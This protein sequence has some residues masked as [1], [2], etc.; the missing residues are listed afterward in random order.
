M[1]ST[2]EAGTMAV[3]PGSHSKGMRPARNYFSY[4]Q[5][6]QLEASLHPEEEDC[7][8]PI[9]I[10][11]GD[12]VAFSADTVHCS[13]K[14]RSGKPRITG[15]LRIINMATLEEPRPLYKALSFTTS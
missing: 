12:L 13:L 4:D 10:D 11:V 2:V 6:R 15:I 5:F 1:K 7:A 8:T 14:N 9:Q 3:I